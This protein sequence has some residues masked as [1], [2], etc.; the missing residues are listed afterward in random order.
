MK[1]R[2]QTKKP[3]RKVTFAALGGGIGA[4][5]ATII[6]FLI[7]LGG[8]EIPNEVETAIALLLSA[9]LAFVFGYQIPP[10]PEDEIARS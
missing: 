1:Y 2:M 7:E 6:T 4:A 5:A 8:T 3:A 9:I 10:S